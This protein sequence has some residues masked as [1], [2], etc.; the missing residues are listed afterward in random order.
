[1]VMSGTNEIGFTLLELVTVLAI[2]GI[3]A[4]IALPNYYNAVIRAREAV[5]KDNL[6]FMR[7]AIDQFY[8]D[9]SKYPQSLQ[10]LVEKKY[11]RTIP[12]D[13]MTDMKNWRT[14]MERVDPEEDPEYEPGVY[15]VKSRS[16]ERSTEGTRY[17]S[18]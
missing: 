14:I 13:P 16:T 11:L 1:M 7:D 8:L 9:N 18:W 17:S 12:K 2:I 6:F 4:T 15:D 10:E 3:L 5:L